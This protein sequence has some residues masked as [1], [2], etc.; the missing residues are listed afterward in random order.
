MIWLL[1]IFSSRK[2]LQVFIVAVY[3]VKIVTLPLCFLPSSKEM[4]F[5][6][7]Q[8][9]HQNLNACGNSSVYEC[10]SFFI[11]ESKVYLDGKKKIKENGV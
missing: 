9:L 8:C 2:L 11:P 1:I 3:K 4:S 5:I 6:G 10:V 7:H